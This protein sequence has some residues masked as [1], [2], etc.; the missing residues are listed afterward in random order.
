MD[1]SQ[2]SQ[3]ITDFIFLKIQADEMRQKLV[4]LESNPPKMLEKEV[5]TW[6]EAINYAETEKKY[7]Q[8]IET[9]RMGIATRMQ[10]TLDKEREMGNLLPISNKFILFAIQINGKDETYKIGYF[11]DSYGFKIEKV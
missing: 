4:D 9:A 6:E 8:D 3:K 10:I 11:P 7:K 2:I 5:L 1:Y